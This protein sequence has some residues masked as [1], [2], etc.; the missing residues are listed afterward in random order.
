MYAISKAHSMGHFGKSGLKRQLRSHFDFKRLDELVE[1][2]VFK[3]NDCQLFTGSA[4]K[5]PLVPVYVPMEAWEYISIDF[6]GPMPNG[7][8]VLVV[9]DLCTKYPV[10]ILLN[11]TKA[12]TAI[13]ALDENFY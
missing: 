4:T 6:F 1:K 3:C 9:Q 8:F 11:N 7:E 12:K 5:A 13:S 10:A 2:E